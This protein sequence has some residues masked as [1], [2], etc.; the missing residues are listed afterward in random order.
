MERFETGSVSSDGEVG[1]DL[2]DS[3]MEWNTE[4]VGTN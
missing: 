1:T 3:H 4:N 2:R